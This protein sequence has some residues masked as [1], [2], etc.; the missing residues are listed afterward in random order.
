MMAWEQVDKLAWALVYMTASA[1][2][3]FLA[4]MMAL[5]HMMAWEQTHM[6]A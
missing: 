6:L 5:G 2:V 3:M 4:H 1:H